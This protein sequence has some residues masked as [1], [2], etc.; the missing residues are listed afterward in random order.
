MITVMHGL[1]AIHHSYYAAH[2]QDAMTVLSGLA[3]QTLGKARL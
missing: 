2:G 3:A 1:W